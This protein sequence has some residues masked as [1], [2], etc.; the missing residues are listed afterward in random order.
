[1]H[2]D[3][4]LLLL[5]VC[6]DWLE[7]DA[8]AFPSGAQRNSAGSAAILMRVHRRYARKV[9]GCDR[10]VQP[11]ARDLNNRLSCV[12]FDATT[13]SDDAMQTD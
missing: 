5:H 10:C 11:F 9:N 1:M 12:S 3:D 8:R 2:A 13:F 4:S 7:V 6:L